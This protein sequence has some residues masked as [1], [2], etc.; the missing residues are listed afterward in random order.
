MRAS[1]RRESWSRLY[2]VLTP[3]RGAGNGRGVGFFD[4]IPRP[5]DSLCGR[6]CRPWEPPVAEFP[7]AVAT[8]PLGLART[9]EVAVAVIGVWAFKA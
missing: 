8:G 3:G 6:Q 9:E 4:D 5:D 1:G 2:R 7:C